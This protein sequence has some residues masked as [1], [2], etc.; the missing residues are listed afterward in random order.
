MSNFA[1]VRVSPDTV[2][3]FSIQPPAPSEELVRKVEELEK[4]VRN[5]SRLTERIES[6]NRTVDQL[7]GFMLTVKHGRGGKTSKERDNEI[8]AIVRY[9]ALQMKIEPERMFEMSKMDAASNARKVAMWVAYQFRPYILRDIARVFRRR[10]H[11][12]VF[13]A[14]RS[15][16]NSQVALAQ[17]LLDDYRRIHHAEA[18]TAPGVNGT[19]AQGQGLAE[20]D[21][22]A[23]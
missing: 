18:E 20:T 6:L 8:E 5:L 15:M 19:N 16:S 12:T 3:R 10:D 1:S 7:T 9:V 14:I 21:E 22:R 4:K 2:R 23:V 13:R 11:A 17:K